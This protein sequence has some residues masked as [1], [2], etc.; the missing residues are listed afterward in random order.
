MSFESKS[1]NLP[2][3]ETNSLDRSLFADQISRPKKE[4]R[5]DFRQY[6][7]DKIREK[8]KT[9]SRSD[10][11]SPEEERRETYQRYLKAFD[12]KERD[13]R[14]KS[15][16]DLGCGEEAEFVKE[17]IEKGV[18]DKI[19]GLDR[20]INLENADAQ[21]K[22]HLFEKNYFGE[23]PVKDLDLIVT[24]A[25]IPE[26]IE[27]IETGRELTKVAIENALEALQ[28][29]GELRIYPIRL[30]SPDN[31]LPG[32]ADIRKGWLGL[33]DELSKT[34]RIKWELRPIDITIS[35]LKNE[36]T[37]LTETL[38]IRKAA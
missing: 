18:S 31:D 38:I 15:I 12:L 16:L 9:E 25:S 5:E 32:I 29:R 7:A 21:L 22:N 20:K 6:V 33:L 23:L 24:L 1:F 37:W 14:G 36:D 34:H 30:A 13:L 28:E 17:L 8:V 26:P 3:S 19:Y 2:S 10:K 11:L 4:W 35:G 27:P